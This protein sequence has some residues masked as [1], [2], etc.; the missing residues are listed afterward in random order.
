MS[1]IPY[2]QRMEKVR[3]NAIGEL[4]KFGANPVLISFAG[5]YP[6]GS[7]FP[8]R[9][10]NDVYGT[11]ILEHGSQSLQYTVPEGNPKLREQLS[12]RATSKG[13]PCTFENIMI[14]QGSQQGLDFVSKMLVDPADI[15]VTESPTFLGALIAFNP[16]QPRYVGIPMDEMGMKTE[17]LEQQL[18]A[19]LKPKLLYTV[20]D[21]QNPSGVTMSATRR[22][23]LIALANQYNFIILEDTAYREL[24]YRGE[25]P[26]TL[27]SLDTQDRVIMLGSLSKILA[28][29]MRLGWAIAS[30]PVIERLTLL[31]I[32]ADTQCSTLNMAAASLFIERYDLD[33]HIEKLRATYLHKKNLMLEMIRQH[34]PQEV[35]CTD[36]DGG[37]FTWLTFPKGFDTTQF[38]RDHALSKAKVAYVPGL[39]F[40]PSGDEHNHARMNFSGQTEANIVKGVSA[41]GAL[42]KQVMAKA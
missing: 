7:Q 12:S 40:F 39:S 31:K 17:L 15:V 24:R 30:A 42:A 19:G 26:A 29:G 25:A 11:A 20:P 1:I 37:L 3:P 36:P 28:P 21:F 8:V 6:D 34:F 35:T 13:T 18:K 4:L 33:Q 38:M 14:L 32:A 9:Q 41:L 22:A 16:C 2:A 10:L 23:H 5:G 27:K